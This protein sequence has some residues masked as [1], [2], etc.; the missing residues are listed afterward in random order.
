[1]FGHW[2]WV[3]FGACIVDGHV[4]SPKAL[5]GLIDKVAHVVLMTHV[6]ADKLGFHAKRAKFFNQRRAGVV[7]STGND[8]LGAFVGEGQRRSA[9]NSSQSAGN[10][11]TGV[12]M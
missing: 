12:L 10:L 8:D 7:V 9:S 6:G 4:K 3:A 5:Y 1:M 2:A 11:T